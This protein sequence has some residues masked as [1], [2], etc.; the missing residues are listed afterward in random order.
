[1]VNTEFFEYQIEVELDDLPVRG[2]LSDSG[3]AKLNK[4]LENQVLKRLDSGDVWVWCE[5]RVI[6]RWNGFESESEW[7]GG[8]CYKD[9]ADFKK[10]GYYDDMKSEA[11][12][13][14]VRYLERAATSLRVLTGPD[15]IDDEVALQRADDD[16]EESRQLASGVWVVTS[17]VYWCHPEL[18][19]EGEPNGPPNV[20]YVSDLESGGDLIQ[21][22]QVFLSVELAQAEADKSNATA[23]LDGSI[24]KYHR[25]TQLPVRQ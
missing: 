25:V 22:H 9:E 7:L 4:R 10:G 15:E 5:V 8:C 3:D 11:G 6:A 18:D 21:V 16:R 2:N 14:L 23:E 20:E 24:G 13:A 12:L 17:D 19:D 1:M